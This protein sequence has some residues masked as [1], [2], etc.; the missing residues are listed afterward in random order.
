MGMSLA[1]TAKALAADDKGL[2]AIDE[3]AATCN[4]RFAAL[5]IPQTEEARRQWRELILSTPG[6]AQSISGVI[7]YDETLFQTDRHGAMLLDLIAA[8]G[9]IAGIKVDAGKVPLPNTEPPESI[10]EGLD[11]LA[12]RLAA[13][14]GMGLRF[15]KWRAV[16]AIGE[17]QPSPRAIAANAH[18]LARYAALCQQEGLVPIIEPEVLMTGAHPLAACA[19]ATE[20]V[21][22]ATFAQCYTQGVRLEEMVLKVNMVLPG[23]A[24]PDQPDPA[25]IAEATLATLRRSVPSAVPAVLFLSGGQGAEL[26]SARLNAIHLCAGRQTPAPL[27][28]SFARAI[29]QPALELWR[30]DDRQVGAAQAAIAHRAQCNRAARRGDYLAAMEQAL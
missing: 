6:L 24:C 17:G 1:D 29:Q 23:L 2:L 27:S 8:S 4:K 12:R 19:L 18:A 21:L 30:G 25:T 10:T 20:V 16:F 7:L 5:G 22:R 15:A 26:A 14:R 28:F 11:G 3:S 9:M 13:Y